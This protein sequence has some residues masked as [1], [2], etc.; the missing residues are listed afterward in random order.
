[1]DLNNQPA[2]KLGVSERR[3]RGWTGMLFKLAQDKL[4]GNGF[5]QTADKVS[6]LDDTITAR[7]GS[8]RGF[9]RPDARNRQRIQAPSDQIVLA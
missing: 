9:Q 1:M 3:T 5:T 2:S 8:W 6:G 4:S 7:M